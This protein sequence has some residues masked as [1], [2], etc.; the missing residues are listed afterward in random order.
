MKLVVRSVRNVW[1][2]PL[3][4]VLVIALLSTSLMFVAAMMSLSANSQQEIAAVHKKVGTG[5][6]VSYASN[7]ARNA[8]QNGGPVISG[9][10]TGNGNGPSF[11]GKGPTP[12]PNSAVEKIRKT[13]GVANVQESLARPDMDGEVKGSQLTD[14]SGQAVNAPLFVN[15]IPSDAT[16][17]TLMG[18][19]TPTLVAGRGFR[20][21]DANANVALMDEDV[22][23]ANHLHVGST[24]KLHGTI[25]TL[26]GL[27]TT[28]NQFSGSSVILPLATM[29][30]VFG[31]DGVDSV[32]LN[33]T[34]YE[35]V[36]AVAAKLHSAL[37]K[38]YDVVTQSAQ[39]SNVFNALQVAQNSIQVALFVSF[40]IAA[41]V[42]VFAVLMLVRERTAEIAILKT[43]GASHLQVLR[44]FWTEIAAL[45]VTAAALAV[46]LLLALGPF[47]SQKFDIDA[48]ALVKAS[49]PGASGP[50]MVVNGSMAGSLTTT[51]PTATN[52]LSGVHLAAATLTTQTLLMIVMIGIGLALLTSIIPTWSVAYTKP[53]SVLRKVTY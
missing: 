42:T 49:G 44:Q 15:G 18:G 45:S 43:I 6:T 39:Y 37:G 4:M 21:S 51:G 16:N 19:D 30:R 34:S 47:I 40:L 46:L 48:S 32:T 26:I 14:P 23:K 5:I 28:T 36:E 3:R 25:F 35:Q 13:Q 50:G 20:S 33:T 41:A 38:A 12:I 53:A 29:Q 11:A 27:Y 9:S 10:S 22:A 52:P 31:I 24:F 7:D 17:F 1:R 8:Q 2:N